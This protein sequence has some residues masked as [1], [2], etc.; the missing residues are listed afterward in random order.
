MQRI[1]W[2][3]LVLGLLVSCS[4]PTDRAGGG[5][6]VRIDYASG[7]TDRENSMFKEIQLSGVFADSKTFVDSHPKLP[8]AEIAELYHVRQQQA[9]FDL[10]AFVHRYFELPPSIASGFVS[11]TSRPVEKHIDILWDVLTRQPDRQ[12]AGTLLPLPYPYVVPGGRFREIYYWDSYFTMLGLQ[13]SK[14]WD[15]MEGMVNNFSHL[16]DTI[17]FIPNGN[18]TYYEGRSQPPFYALMVELLANKQGESVLLAHLPHLRREYEFWM[19]GAAK[20]SPAAPAHR[21][22]VLL[23]DGSILNRYWDDIAAPRPESFR[24]DYELAE[25]I[26][27]NKR[28]LYRH[29]RAAAESGWDFS[30][31]WFKDGN[32]MAS[33]H[34]T[35][36]IPVDLNA[37]VFNLERMLAHIYGLQGDQDQATHYY[38]LAEQRKQALLRYCWN[39]QQGF[40][41]DYDYVAAQQTPVMSLAAVYPLYFS[42]VDQRTGDR[43]AEQIEAHFIQAGG[44]TTTLATTGQQW[45]APNGWAPLQWLTIQGLRN[46][47]HNSAA[48]QIKQR[49]IALNQRVYRNTGKLVEKYNVYDLDVAGGG[50]EYELQDGFGWTN[51]VLLHLLNE[52]TP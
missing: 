42:M 12:E 7:L 1:L 25:A 15:L 28:E 17:G 44:V 20:L 19:E 11:D 29:I 10:A 26:G 36:I 43:V 8:L 3:S 18:R 16:I 49:W 13:A 39:A 31:R 27:G 32:G 46:Y 40:F 34:T 2:L 33:I 35:D 23:P 50:G 9:G 52:S 24:E 47:H 48:E 38:Q 21:R 51:G 4:I 37:L 45:D 6:A 5:T 22:V 30:S 14:R 41:H